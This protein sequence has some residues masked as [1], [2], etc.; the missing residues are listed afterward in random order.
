MARTSSKRLREKSD[1]LQEYLAKRVSL[2]IDETRTSRKPPLHLHKREG[3]V[4]DCTVNYVNIEVIPAQPRMVHTEW[5]SVEQEDVPIH[6]YPGKVLSI[7]L[8]DLKL[9]CD[10][11]KDRLMVIISR[12]IWDL[13]TS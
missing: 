6:L 1:A 10:I 4:R 13:S 9:A 12:S 8:E 7:P 5:N 11:D 2:R 3:I